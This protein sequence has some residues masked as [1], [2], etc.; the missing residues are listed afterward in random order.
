MG[1]IDILINSGSAYSV[2][3][4][5]TNDNVTQYNSSWLTGTPNTTANP[6]PV[7]NFTQE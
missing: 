4:G 3:N 6:G 2:E 1:L 5:V 7:H